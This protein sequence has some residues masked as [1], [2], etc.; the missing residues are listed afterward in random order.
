M[1]G[2]VKVRVLTHECYC[3]GLASLMGY[4]FS[5]TACYVGKIYGLVCLVAFVI[6][7]F[8]TQ[9]LFLFC[10]LQ[11]MSRRFEAAFKTIG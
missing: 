1:G 5:G 10:N 2:I 11:S 8:N 9:L 4:G 3:A 7:H 6:Y